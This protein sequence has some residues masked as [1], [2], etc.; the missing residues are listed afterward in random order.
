MGLVASAASARLALDA[1]I[2]ARNKSFQALS[3]CVNVEQY[4]E[5]RIRETIDA[6][7]QIY[8][9]PSKKLNE[10][11]NSFL[12]VANRVFSRILSLPEEDEN[13]DASLT[14]RVKF[15]TTR[16]A[17]GVGETTNQKVV[18]PCQAQI[19]VVL[20]QLQK[21]MVVIEYL[22]EGKN[23]TL[24]KMDNISDSMFTSV[25]DFR[26][27]AKKGADQ[28]LSHPEDTLIHYIHNW[29]NTLIQQF[30]TL[31]ERGEELLNEKTQKKVNEA[32]DYVTQFSST[33]Q[34]ADDLY[35]ANDEVI[36]EVKKRLAVVF[37]WVS[38]AKKND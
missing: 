5:E 30:T 31:R 13:K 7:Y 10:H 34:N 15:L 23:K 6:T 25:N 8:Q 17:K 14:E 38:A 18:E 20:E 12:D 28:I 22:K 4:V 19:Q 9:S 1:A 29:S 35:T 3:S 2:G 11:T 24:Q 37:E 26:L 16:V 33:L 27:N 36:E 32:V 21:S